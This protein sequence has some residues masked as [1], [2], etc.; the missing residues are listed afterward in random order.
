M[1]LQ[2]YI[3]RDKVRIPD[4]ERKYLLQRVPGDNHLR[5]QCLA[6]KERG[7]VNL[8]CAFNVQYYDLIK[9]T[10]LYICEFVTPTTPSIR[11]YMHNPKARVTERYNIYVQ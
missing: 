2:H 7:G 11:D 8:K 10:K 3:A 5:D 1:T 9:R 6:W 4:D